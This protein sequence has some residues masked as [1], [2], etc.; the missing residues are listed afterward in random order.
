M[1]WLAIS[2][3]SIPQAVSSAKRITSACVSGSAMSCW[4]LVQAQRQTSQAGLASPAAREVA[5][6]DDGIVSVRHLA[7]ADENADV[8][9]AVWDAIPAASGLGEG[10]QRQGE[11]KED[12]QEEGARHREGRKRRSRMENA[13]E[14]Q[15]G[16]RKK[17]SKHEREKKNSTST[18]SLPLSLSSSF[19]ARRR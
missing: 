5:T 14:E 7:V 18:S 8:G 9:D 4:A 11:G 1:H 13:L 19:S 15:G 12:G 6:F 3:G 10:G 17:L 16:L 2:P